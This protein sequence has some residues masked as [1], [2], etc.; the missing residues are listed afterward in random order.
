MQLTAVHSG[1]PFFVQRGLLGEGFLS[2]TRQN[3]FSLVPVV[4]KEVLEKAWTESYCAHIPSLDHLK[5]GLA[6][7][8]GYGSRHL[9]KLVIVMLK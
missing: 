1:T 5:A 9:R 3:G 6:R 8:N 2:R 4:G 7:A